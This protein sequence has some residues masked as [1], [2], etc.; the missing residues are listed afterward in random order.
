V[1]PSRAL[2]SPEYSSLPKAFVC[3]LSRKC[4]VKEITFETTVISEVFMGFLFLKK[5]MHAVS[6]TLEIRPCKPIQAGSYRASERKRRFSRWRN[7]QKK[8]AEKRRKT[9]PVKNKKW[10][11]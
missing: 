5:Q 10:K 2:I 9:N 7:L 1:S 11:R 4:G 3:G 8:L 6:F